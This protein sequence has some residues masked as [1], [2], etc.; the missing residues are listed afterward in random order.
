MRLQKNSVQAAEKIRTPFPT[1]IL[2]QEKYPVI[3]VLSSEEGTSKITTKKHGELFI[4]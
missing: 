4:I 2:V 3:T 1:A